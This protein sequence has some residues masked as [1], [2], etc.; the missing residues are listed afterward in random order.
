MIGE[1]E[2]GD[3]SGSAVA[4]GEQTR[5]GTRSP[6]AVPEDTLALEGQPVGVPG[7][8]GLWWNN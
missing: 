3:A 2:V 5:E 1:S 7:L 4:A 6:C 8:A